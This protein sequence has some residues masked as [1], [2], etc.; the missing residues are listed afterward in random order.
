MRACVR[1]QLEVLNP[2]SSPAAGVAIVVKP[3]PVE[4]ITADNGMAKL[5]VNTV[6]NIN[7]L[8][9]TV[10]TRARNEY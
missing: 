1:L 9:L 3:G 7:E 10:R 8:S 5:T 4:G 2:D 6:A